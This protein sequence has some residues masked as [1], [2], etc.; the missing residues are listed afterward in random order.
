MLTIPTCIV[1]CNQ[2]E[3]DKNSGSVD[4]GGNKDNVG[5]AHQMSDTSEGLQKTS[6]E[7]ITLLEDDT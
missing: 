4:A 5:N 3:N 1:V 2:G 6:G 7:C